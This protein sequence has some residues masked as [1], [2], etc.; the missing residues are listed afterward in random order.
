MHPVTHPYLTAP[1]HNLQ[2]PHGKLQEDRGIETPILIQSSRP[3]SLMRP[4]IIE[5]LQR[6]GDAPTNDFYKN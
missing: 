4:Q 1:V 5:R 2:G 6:P 3:M